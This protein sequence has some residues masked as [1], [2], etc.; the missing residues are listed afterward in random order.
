MVGH[1]VNASCPIIVGGQHRRGTTVPIYNTV[2]DAS[3]GR[4]YRNV[5]D[6]RMRIREP[7]G[8]CGTRGCNAYVYAVDAYETD[9][10]RIPYYEMRCAAGHEHVIPRGVYRQTMPDPS[11]LHV[12][13]VG[14]PLHERTK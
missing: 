2:A 13:D 3:T 6:E 11:R 10:T 4:I 7:V 12:H 9:W 1:G 14:E 5:W 8:T